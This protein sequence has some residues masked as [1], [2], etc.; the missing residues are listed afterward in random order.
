[1]KQ[2]RTWDT[3]SDGDEAHTTPMDLAMLGA[4]QAQCSATSRRWVALRCGAGRLFG[5]VS[6]RLVTTVA[7]LGSVAA[8]LLVWL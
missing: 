5:F 8:A 6:T 4:H 7:V 3:S 1:M 2:T